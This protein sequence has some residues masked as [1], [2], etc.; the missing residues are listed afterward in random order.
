MSEEIKQR[1]KTYTFVERSLYGIEETFRME[2]K[3]RL[4]K[5]A[6]TEAELI[7]R[8]ISQKIKAT[9]VSHKD[10]DRNIESIVIDWI[11]NG[12]K[13]QG[14]EKISGLGKVPPV[15]LNHSDID[16]KIKLPTA[17]DLSCSA[18]EYA[19]S[20]AKDTLKKFRLNST[21]LFVHKDE[22][23]NILEALKKEPKFNIKEIVVVENFKEC[24]WHIIF[25]EQYTILPN[26]R[27]EV[28]SEGI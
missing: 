26:K 22:P 19:I 10:H 9:V 25:L 2:I 12:I 5:I 17:C 3:A 16:V 18:I 15:T 20:T 14:N 4:M 8:E 28:W 27:I 1:S 21:T 24:E 6:E 7:A 13:N 23:P 11:I